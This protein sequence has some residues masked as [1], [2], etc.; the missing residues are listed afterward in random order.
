MYIYYNSALDE[1]IIYICIYNNYNITFTI[2]IHVLKEYKIYIHTYI[3]Q[4]YNKLIYI[5][6]NSIKKCFY[7]N[8]CFRKCHFYLLYS[9][10]N[11]EVS[12]FNLKYSLKRIAA[13]LEIIQKAYYVFRKKVYIHIYIF[14]LLI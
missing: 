14:L 12:S 10:F 2:T 3:I 11:L 1:L 13:Y 9:I 8:E 7:W 5:C 6:I 4:L